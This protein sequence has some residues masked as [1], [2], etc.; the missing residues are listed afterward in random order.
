VFIDIAECELVIEGRDNSDV[1]LFV[2]EL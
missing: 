2:R 1:E